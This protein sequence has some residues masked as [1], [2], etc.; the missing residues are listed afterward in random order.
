[1]IDLPWR[2]DDAEGDPANDVDGVPT[3]DATA[4]AH[5]EALVVCRC[6]D[7]TLVVYEDRVVIERARRSK[8]DDTTV[9][10]EEISGVDYAGGIAIGY[11]QLELVGVA[12]DAGGLFSSPVNERTLHFGGGGRDCAK[13]AR[14][15][16]LERARG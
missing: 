2:N 11:I 13:R 8:F 6:Q 1:M 14:D 10:F 3:N 16:I 9:P 4:D 7:G 5:D 12:L 15:A